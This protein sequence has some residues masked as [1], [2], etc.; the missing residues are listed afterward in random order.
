MNLFQDSSPHKYVRATYCIS[1]ELLWIEE[2]KYYWQPLAAQQW[3]E[4]IAVYR[5][6]SNENAA[7]FYPRESE[8]S[9][10]HHVSTI[11][12]FSSFT[13]TSTHASFIFVF[14]GTKSLISKSKLAEK[15][16]KMKL[17]F[18][19]WNGN[20]AVILGRKFGQLYQ[21][22]LLRSVFKSSQNQLIWVFQQSIC[23]F[24]N[25]VFLFKKVL[26]LFSPIEK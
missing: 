11:L 15:K 14:K 12:S 10:C 6:Q 20:S 3:S 5:K 17:L 21:N 18:T 8:T 22:S 19:F 1:K 23:C 25:L 13:V 2:L 26:I 4:I 16:P 9:I 7:L 24:L